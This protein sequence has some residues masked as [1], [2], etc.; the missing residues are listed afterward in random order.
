M[1][2]VFLGVNDVGHRLYDWLCQREGV[3]V[4]AM[5]TEPEQLELIRSK[6]PEFI[7][8]VGFDHLVPPEILEIPSRGALNL[9]P[10]YLPY[11]RGKSPN[12]WPLVE[13]TTA[14]VTLHHMDEE[15]DTGGIIAR[16]EV[17]TEFSDTGKD[18]HERLEN[19][20][21]DLFTETWPE[22]ESGDVDLTPQNETVGSYHSTADFVE[23]CEL[24]PD[25][26]VSVKPFLDRL[27]ALTFPPFNNAYLDIDGERYYVDVEIKKAAEEPDEK[28]DALLTSY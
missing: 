4:V 27:R 11:N 6:T 12:V 10:A 22:I 8:S 18:L 13:G 25:E 17:E 5:V 2:V 7:V 15:F 16:R 21:F 28:T 19:V 26:T 20:Q 14:G 24:D 23:L 9:H 1:K 3:D